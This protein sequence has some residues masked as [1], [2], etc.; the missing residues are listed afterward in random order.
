MT[1]HLVVYVCQLTG[2]RARPGEVHATVLAR[3]ESPGFSL[4]SYRRSGNNARDAGCDLP[5]LEVDSD[6]K[7]A[8]VEVDPSPQQLSPPSDDMDIDSMNWSSPWRDHD[9]RETKPVCSQQQPHI[10][11]SEHKQE[12]NHSY[13]P[14]DSIYQ[15]YRQ[16]GRAVGFRTSITGEESDLWQH[17]P[18]ARSCAFQDKGQH[19]LILW[20]FLRNVSLSDLGFGTNTDNERIRSYWLSVA[21]AFQAS[22]S[23]R[24][25]FE[26]VV[27]SFL[28]NELGDASSIQH[29]TKTRPSA[30]IRVV[31]SLFVRALSSCSIQRLL[32]SACSIQIDATNSVQLQETFV[33]LV[34]EFYDALC[35]VLLEISATM[36]ETLP[37]VQTFSLANLLDEILSLVY[38]QTR[39]SELRAEIM[40]YLMKRDAAGSLSVALNSACRMFIILV[41]ETN[42][43]TSESI[44]RPSSRPRSG[45]DNLMWNQRWLLEPGSVQL[46]GIASGAAQNIICDLHVVDVAQFM[47]E[48]GCVDVAVDDD[49]SKISLRSAHLEA[50]A[51]PMTLILDGRLRKFQVL[52][53]GLPSMIATAGGWSLGDYTAKLSDDGSSLSV[54]FFTFAE[55][56]FAHGFASQNR[57]SVIEEMW[58]RQ[59]SLSIRLEEEVVDRNADSSADTEDL[60]AF[61]QGTVYGSTF[62]PGFKLSEASAVDR[63]AIWRGAE[64]TAL[65]ELQAGY[66]ALPRVG[67]V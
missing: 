50:V 32:R 26:T 7:F 66:I 22:P 16:A 47:F 20:L 59:V 49:G 33:S 4:I 1:H 62:L 45:D 43:T 29:D 25:R 56:A 41:Q 21:A 37:G 61:V 52:P 6:T 36:A 55:A 64:W 40:D 28:K 67:F 30:V 42:I 63:A 9:T 46:T 34:S 27:D 17:G 51:S 19:L 60:F 38:S 15:S 48:F 5:A 31:A 14:H 12:D 39:F 13:M 35:E 58:M 44:V 2:T 8:A 10:I 11:Q 18:Y 53:S 57:E 3:H 24:Q 65:W 23:V 54:N